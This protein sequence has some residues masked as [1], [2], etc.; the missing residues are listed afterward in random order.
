MYIK[1]TRF[2]E[3]IHRIYIKPRGVKG[4]DW[5]TSSYRMEQEDV[6]QII[7]EW[8]EEWKSSTIDV[9][10]SDEEKEKEKGKE[11]TE[12][13]KDKERTGEKHKAPQDDPKPHKRPKMKAQRN[14]VEDQ[15]GSNDYENIT[16]CV[17]E[18][19]EAPM[20]AIVSS[21]TAMKSVINMKIVE[22]KTLMEQASQLPTPM[23]STYGTLRRGSTSQ[24]RTHFVQILPAIVRLPSG[25]QIEQTRFIELDLARI[26]IE[27][28]KMVQLQV[29]EEL[30]E[31][32][33]STYTQNEKIVKDNAKLQQKY[34]TVSAQLAEK[35]VEEEKL[36]KV[37]ANIGA[38]IPAYNIDPEAPILQTVNS[39]VGQGKELEQKFVKIEEEYKARIVELE[40]KE[41][42]TPPEEH[43]A[44]L[45]KLKG[46]ATPIEL[47]LAKTQKLLDNT[48]STWDT[49]EDLDNL[50]EAYAALQKHQRELDEVTTAMKD[51]APLQRMLKMGESKKLQTELQRLRAHEV[52][53]LKTL[54]PWQDEVSAIA[55]KFNAKFTE[56]QAMQMTVVS[57][58]E[59]P[60]TAKLVNIAGE[61]V[62]LMSQDIARLQ[63]NYTQFTAKLWQILKSQKDGASGSGT[64]HK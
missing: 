25:S 17:Q 8:P 11:K 22:L 23:P 40:A 55:M 42:V 20:I 14:P 16:T 35:T 63:D 50:V 6:E 48:T 5:H 7:K 52:E 61:C 53:Y 38:K 62:N 59:E 4:I 15:L 19:L 21:Q 26:P 24:G 57:L 10:D 3:D 56:F 64:S 9:C 44:R 12:E 49:M 2:I 41:L 13:K 34:K 54:Q 47:L 58:L 37:V 33:L 30:R 31:Q 1:R 51:L 43:E 32:E 29:H 45:S 36:K 46:F 39:I 18:T 27:T 60:P 28:L